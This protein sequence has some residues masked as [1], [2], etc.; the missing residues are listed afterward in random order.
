[1]YKIVWHRFFF[2]GTFYKKKMNWNLWLNL[3]GGVA[4]LTSYA[5]FLPQKSS[6][7]WWVGL[8]SQIQMVFWVSLAVAGVCFVASFVI[9]F[10]Q[11]RMWEYYMMMML[12][13]VGATLWAPMVS[14]RSPTM[15]LISL[16]LTSVGALGMAIFS[17]DPLIFVLMFFVF[18][19]CFLM[20]NIVWYLAYLN[21]MLP[22]T[23]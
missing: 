23:M 9:A 12:F 19:H 3:L 15:V 21:Y 14:I 18:L 10:R 5:V 6:T 4:V 8:P 13:Y 22:S 2:Y 16:F 11:Q 17:Y 1:M 20:D 7:E